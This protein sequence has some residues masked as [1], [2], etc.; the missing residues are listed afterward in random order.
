MPNSRAVLLLSAALLVTSCGAHAK[1]GSRLV[2]A[3]MRANA[4]E[5]VRRFEWAK[6]AQQSAVA[7]AAPWLKVSDEDLWKMIPG[8][9]LP[10]AVYIARGLLYEGKRDACPKCGKPIRYGG[11][12]DFWKQDWKVTCA[13]CQEVFPKNDFRAYD[14]T[15]LDAYGCF[16]RGRGDPR[17]LVTAEHP[18][19]QDPLCKLYV[20]DGYGM[21]D[22]AYLHYGSSPG[23]RTGTTLRQ[24]TPTW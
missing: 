12:A 13:H 17:L 7:S 19:S 5:N 21:T 18:D 15:A 2:T 10:R 1:E 14:Q 6:S 9:E 22:A 20:D 4:R 24:D 3:E 11:K 23:S 8:Q 16:R